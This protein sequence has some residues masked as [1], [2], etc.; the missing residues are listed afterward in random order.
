MTMDAFRPSVLAGIDLLP[1]F[2]GTSMVSL[3]FAFDQ[4]ADRR[5]KSPATGEIHLGAAEVYRTSESVREAQFEGE[6]KSRGWFQEGGVSQ[7]R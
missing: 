5:R 6:W 1:K 2:S 4:V 7:V 3:P